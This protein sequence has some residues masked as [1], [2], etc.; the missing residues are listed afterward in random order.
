M[1]PEAPSSRSSAAARSASRRAPR[2]SRASRAPRAAASASGEPAPAWTP[3]RASRAR[4]SSSGYLSAPKRATAS[5]SSRAA[6]AA[7]P[8]AAATLARQQRRLGDQ[9]LAARAAQPPGGSVRGVEVA[10][11]QRDGAAQHEHGHVPVGA[12]VEQRPR[13]L[14]VAAVEVQPHQRCERRGLVVESG[15]QPRGLVAAALA[16]AQLGEHSERQRAAAAPPRVR[17]APQR[18]GEHRL[19]ALPVAGA[20]EDRAVDRAAP[21]LDGREAAPLGEL[22]HG[23]APLRGA[24]EVGEAVAGDE[25]RAAG[26][27]A[28]ERV[29]RLAAEGDGHRLVEQRHALLHAALAHDGVA[30]LC[31]GHALDVGVGEPVRD[32]QRGAGVP[33]GVRGVLRALG[34]LDLEPAEL[35]NVARAVEQPPRPRQPA[36]GGGVAA[37]DAVL[38]G[39]IGGEPPRAPRIAPALVGRVRLPAAIDRRVA[40]AEPPQRLAQAVERL[41]IVRLLLERD[42]E[43]IARVSPVGPSEVPPAGLVGR[44]GRHVSGARACS[45]SRPPRCPAE[46]WC[47]P[48]CPAP[49]PAR[50]CP[51]GRAWSWSCRACS[52]PP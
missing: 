38:G 4:A 32:V 49:G 28:G 16:H 44:R 8:R 50:T 43:R 46:R 10:R 18:G 37:V 35:G 31:Q 19:G 21:G 6:A 22:D 29:V 23:L 1:R 26:V 14:Q 52:P 27:A 25:R 45:A 11:R 40:F 47:R 3:A 34:L 48:S 7:S 5:S 13:V 12:A 24:L 41:R 39:E 36:G 17:L 30:E 9:I 51:C 42:R 2:R 20:D 33:L 15:E